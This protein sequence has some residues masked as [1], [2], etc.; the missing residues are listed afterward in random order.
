MSPK[1]TAIFQLSLLALALGLLLLAVHPEPVSVP[2]NLD[3]DGIIIMEPH[4]LAVTIEARSAYVY[5][6]LADKVL[7]E[8]DA[9]L[10]W[11]LASLTKLMSALVASELVP[12]Y[13]L[14]KITKDDLREEGDTG[15]H[16]DEEWNIN[17]LIDYSLVV[18]SNDGMKAIASVAGSFA[19]S[20]ATTT[21][22][23]AFIKKMNEKAHSLGLKETYFLNQS[24]LDESNTLSGG[25]GS[26]K[27]VALLVDYILK[28]NPHLL[29]AT[30]FKETNV[31]SSNASHD[32]VNTNKAILSIPNIIAS[33]TGFTNLS[34]GNVVVALN[35]GINH[36]IIISV[37]G[38]SY[39]GRFTDLTDLAEATLTYLTSTS[40]IQRHALK[41]AQ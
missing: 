18:S 39:D 3:E 9:E 20:S 26:A 31:S 17:K 38:S 22:E 28:K 5:D 24:G 7:Y 10:Q 19:G 36:P 32:A 4:F 8:K 35:A 27:D 41:T 34:G 11:P 25:Y 1:T 33:K 13:M 40:T 15:L 29:E 21:P 12:N 16:P 23:Q 6:V 2:Q 14:V 37:L 30:S